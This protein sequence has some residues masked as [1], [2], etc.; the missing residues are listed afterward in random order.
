MPYKTEYKGSATQCHRFDSGRREKLTTAH[1]RGEGIVLKRNKTHID[2][3]VF[4]STL[5]YVHAGHLGAETGRH[6][7]V[8]LVAGSGQFGREVHVL[9]IRDSEYHPEC[10][11]ARQEARQVL[12]QIQRI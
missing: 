1:E 7:P 3:D 11:G 4:F 10:Q 9:P 6:P 2:E 12:L 5:V 8:H